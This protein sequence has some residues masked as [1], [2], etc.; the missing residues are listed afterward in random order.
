[1]YSFLTIIYKYLIQKRSPSIEKM[2]REDPT[3]DSNT[4]N[5][6]VFQLKAL[7]V[8]G[9]I[10]MIL[11]GIITCIGIIS[12]SLHQSEKNCKDDIEFTVGRYD[13]GCE[14]RSK[15][16][17]G[18]DGAWVGLSLWRHLTPWAYDTE[19]RGIAIMIAAFLTFVMTITTCS[20]AMC[21]GKENEQRQAVNVNIANVVPGQMPGYQLTSGYQPNPYLQGQMPP[22]FITGS[23]QIPGN[24]AA[25]SGYP[26]YPAVQYGMIPNQ[27]T[28]IMES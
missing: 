15:K 16:I 26:Q 25:V 20:Y 3:E 7:K 22:H 14:N 6:I 9:A 23:G 28:A 13:V 24:M 1:M 10:Q 18:M 2:L 8:F 19:A 17:I 27:Q 4:F 11:G 5:P 21:C 12:L